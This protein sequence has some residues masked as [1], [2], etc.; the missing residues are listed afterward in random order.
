MLLLIGVIA[1]AL[2]PL[3]TIANS[4]LSRS[5]G[6]A[7][8]ASLVSFSVGTVA[9]FIVTLMMGALPNLSE[10]SAQPPWMLTGGA[11]GVI[12]LSG[13][14]LL[15]PKL[16][17]VQTV[18]LPISGQI[19][20][21]MIIDNFGLFDAPVLPAD[22]TRILG[23]SVVMLGVLA[24]VW[25]P[26]SSGQERHL[27]LQIAGI[28]FGMCLAAQSAINGQLG[29]SLDTPISAALISFAVGTATLLVINI[30]LRWR[31]NLWITQNTQPLWMWT[32]GLLGAIFVST[33]ALLAPRIGTGLT[34][35][36]T[37]S[38]MMLASVLIDRARG[39]KVNARQIAG[40]ATVI[41]G[42]SLL[43][44]GNS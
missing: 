38:G 4:R 22:P 26:K 32:G 29:M 21:G 33:N 39:A 41:A 23:A 6:T 36:A 11:L 8:S 15:F 24:C 7:L 44:L 35:L 18:I 34:V 30:G 2:V 31:P 9:L 3:Q 17:A 25:R 42:V 14:I 37:L 5:T 1:G 43:T 28:G 16:G 12:A 13:N 10:V 27:P 40:L 19:I 20:A